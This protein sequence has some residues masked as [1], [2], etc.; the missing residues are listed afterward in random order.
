MTWLVRFRISRILAL[1][2]LSLGCL[3]A[4]NQGGSIVIKDGFVFV[5]TIINGRGPFR[6]LVDTGTTTSLLAPDSATAA[7]LAYD[8]R[9]VLI[10]LGDETLVAATSTGELRVGSTTATG[11]EIAVAPIGHVRKIDRGAHGILGQSFL[12]RSA[13]LIDYA[14]KKLWLGEDA[15][16]R[17]VELPLILSAQQTN[18]RTILPVTLQAGGPFWRLTLDSG[19]SNLIVNCNKRCPMITDLRSDGRIMALVG[20][21]PVLGGT[22]R[23]VEIGGARMSFV[24]ALLIDAD[25]ADGQDEGVIPSQWFSA[26]YVDGNAGLVRLAQRR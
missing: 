5:D 16:R 15:M 7:G 8:H 2:L 18:G 1:A 25:L 21:R 12:S 20:E 10:S 14:R 13:Y 6:M 23:Q 11:V 17:A 3:A 9:V 4:D 22:L 24:R 26:V 19:A